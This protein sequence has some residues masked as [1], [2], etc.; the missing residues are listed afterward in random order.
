MHYTHT[1]TH[2]H[3]HT[4]THTHTDCSRNWVCVCHGCVT[5]TVWELQTHSPCHVISVWLWYLYTVWELQTRSLCHVMAVWLILYGSCRPAHVVMSYLCGCDTFIQYGSCRPACLV[6]S[7]LWYFY[8]VWELPTC[9]PCILSCLCGCDT[10][11][12]TVWEL[13][14]CLSCIMSYLC[15]CDTFT[16]RELQ[17]CS[18]C[19]VISVWLWYIYS[20]GV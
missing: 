5:D 17:T 1:H 6:M 9:L 8:L 16:V 10:F 20:R 11:C 4:P 14:T 15:G 3:T 18:L 2:T 7:W 12:L 19:H 13:Q